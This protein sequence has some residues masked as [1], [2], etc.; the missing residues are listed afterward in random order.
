MLFPIVFGSGKRL[1]TDSD[2][3]SAFVTS[4][5]EVGDGI[6]VLTDTPVHD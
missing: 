2:N 6:A 1:F 5:T 3:A 4:I